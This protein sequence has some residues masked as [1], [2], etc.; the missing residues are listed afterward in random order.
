[1]NPGDLIAVDELL[2]AALST[3]PAV[4]PAEAGEVLTGDL[5]ADCAVCHMPS[6]PHH[7]PSWCAAWNVWLCPN[8]RWTRTER[9]LMNGRDPEQVAQDRNPA[10]RPQ[11][12]ELPVEEEITL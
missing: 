7:E 5:A 6:R 4:N 10:W 1:V 8:C 2:A 9:E 3:A 12:P 11:H